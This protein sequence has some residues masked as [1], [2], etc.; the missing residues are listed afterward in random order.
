MIG[1]SGKTGERQRN[2]QA[3]PRAV[4]RAEKCA[5][6]CHPLACR[7]ASDTQFGKHRQNSSIHRV[8][9][10]NWVVWPTAPFLRSLPMSASTASG[11]DASRPLASTGIEGLDDILGGGLTPNRLYL[12][13]G[14]PGSGKTTLAFQFLREGVRRGEHGPVHRAVGNRRRN[15]RAVA[16]SHGWSLDGI[17]VR[18]LVPTEESLQTRR[19]I[20]DVSPLRGGT[21]RGDETDP[22]RRRRDEAGAGRVG[23]TLR[24]SAAGGE[25]VALPA[26]DARAQAFLCRPGLH[27]AAARRPHDGRSAICK[28]KALRTA[29]FVSSS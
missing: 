9:L 28:C 23:L 19:A 15:P 10:D 1:A 29:S 16:A 22:H 3:Q 21:H 24:V 6:C 14:M 12:V 18:E 5:A 27:S 7:T 17:F 20:H 13:E 2:S 4:A 11:E 26:A 25:P 8:I